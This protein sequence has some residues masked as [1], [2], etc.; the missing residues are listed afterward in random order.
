MITKN[1]ETIKNE[2]VKKLI[3]AT[4]TLKESPIVEY[5]YNN[6]DYTPSLSGYKLM[7]NLKTREFSVSWAMM[8]YNVTYK[9]KDEIVLHIF[10]TEDNQ[11]RLINGPVKNFQEWM[12]GTVIPNYQ[13]R[14]LEFVDGLDQV[15]ELS[16]DGL[17]QVRADKNLVTDFAKLGTQLSE[18][19]ISYQDMKFSTL[20]YSMIFKVENYTSV[21]PCPD[22]DFL[23]N[24]DNVV[25]IVK[26]TIKEIELSDDEKEQVLKM[27]KWV[28]GDFTEFFYS[29]GMRH[30]FEELESLVEI[31]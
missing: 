23:P 19:K 17:C 14:L 21:M 18:L 28:E 27:L 25:K 5:F 29:E 8:D 15:R 9:S 13:N 7:F 12:M 30:H 11:A 3:K 2:T 4:E 22:T 1:Q 16:C 31:N 24:I 6:P 10:K 26:W 20:L